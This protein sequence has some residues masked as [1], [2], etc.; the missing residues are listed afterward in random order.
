VLIIGRPAA[1][2][3]GEAVGHQGGGDF[4]HQP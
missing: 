1:F 4:L 3:A 2:D